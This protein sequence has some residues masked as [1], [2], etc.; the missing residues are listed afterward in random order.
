MDHR[1]GVMLGDLD[2]GVRG[3]GGGA[4]DEQRHLESAALHFL[5]DVDHLVERR[6]DQ[7]GQADDVRAD[8]DRLVE[9]LVAGNHDAHVGDF[10]AVAGEHHADDVLADV[11]DVALDG[12][13]EETAGGAPAFGEASRPPR[14]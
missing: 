11:V 2:G 8:L 1:T 14:R 12:G 4:T 10:E 5:G 9:D 13:D 6:R 3:G 7:T